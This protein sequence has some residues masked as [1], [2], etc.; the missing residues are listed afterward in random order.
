MICSHFRNVL[1]QGSIAKILHSFHLLIGSYAEPFQPV[2]ENLLPRTYFVLAT[3][4]N[5]QCENR[6]WSLGSVKRISLCFHVGLRHFLALAPSS[7]DLRDNEQRRTGSAMMSSYW[8]DWCSFGHQPR[9]R[10]PFRFHL[11]R[12]WLSRLIWMIVVLAG[13]SPSSLTLAGFLGV[14]FRRWVCSL[15]VIDQASS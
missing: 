4:A 2:T 7:Y 1:V 5:K 11:C 14:G 12:H 10:R 13:A 15:P 8:C 3:F 9:S 6:N